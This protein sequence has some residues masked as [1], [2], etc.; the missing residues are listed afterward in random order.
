M[1]EPDEEAY[2]QDL[3]S[4][5]SKLPRTVTSES[6]LKMFCEFSVALFCF[7]SHTLKEINHL[8]YFTFLIN[9]NI[10]DSMWVAQLERKKRTC[11][12]RIGLSSSNLQNMLLMNNNTLS[13]GFELYFRD[14][15]CGFLYSSSL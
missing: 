1:H 10:R 5:R 12:P 3:L 14:L 13:K 7:I 8:I 15:N 6:I 4:V 11:F 2:S 9:K